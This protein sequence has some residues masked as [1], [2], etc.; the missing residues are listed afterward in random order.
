M[1]VHVVEIEALLII[2]S[3]VEILPTP[4]TFASKVAVAAVVNDERP[5]TVPPKFAFPTFVSSVEV[6]VIA[7]KLILSPEAVVIVVGA[8]TV[9]VFPKFT[10]PAVIPHSAPTV[11]SPLY[12]CTPEVEIEEQLIFVVP[13]IPSEVS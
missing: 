11:V 8:E 5:V 13:V 6:P 2:A 10:L 4:E 12:V 9:S 1:P 3:A 7:A